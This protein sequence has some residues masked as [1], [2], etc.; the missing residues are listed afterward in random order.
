MQLQL[1][2]LWS[3]I[4]WLPAYIWQRATRNRITPTSPLHL[5]IAIADH[6]EPSMTHEFRY[7]DLRE[8]ERRLV[9]WCRDYPRMASPWVDSDGYCVR[10]TYFYPAEQ[11][12]RDLLALLVEHCREGWGEIEIHL[13]HGVGERDTAANTKRVLLEFRD[14]LT[15]H[16]CLSR[17]DGREQPR[18][19]FVH[20]NWALANSAG[21][22][23]CGVDEEM[24]I[25]AE[26]GC[27]ADFTLPSAP[28]PAQVAK[29]NSLYECT[30]PLHEAIPH[31]R[32]RNLIVGRRP[33]VFPLIVQGPLMLDF[34]RLSGKAY[35]PRIENSEITAR[36]LPTMDRLQL[37]KRAAI[38]VVGRPDWLFI[39]LH[40][41]GLDPREQAAMTGP[42]LSNFLRDLIATTRDSGYKVHFVTVREMVNIILAACDD[43]NGNP[44]EYRNYRLELIRRHCEIA[45][46]LLPTHRSDRDNS[47]SHN[48]FRAESRHPGVD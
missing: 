28:H 20:G 16:G 46:E 3:N 7:A 36:N 43:R 24:E 11:Y 12:N 38:A 23:F 35:F 32:G 10:H 6:F 1:H 13:H 39:K 48:Q 40:C 29:I 27:Y 2:K 25:L 45:S 19:A 18:Y 26:T 42:S 9:A 22:Q 34:S 15:T 8:Q 4:G 5:I 30:L 41:H 21:G 14:Y 33:E 17:L 44:G 47:Q 37:W 31:R